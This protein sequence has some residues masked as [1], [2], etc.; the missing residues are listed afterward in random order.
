MYWDISVP[1]SYNALF[2][3]IIGNRGG[4]KTYGCKKYVISRFL[5]TG[6]QF[7]YVRRYKQELKKISTF[8]AAVSQEFPETEFNVYEGKFIINGEIAGY[9]LPL[10]TAKI[11]KS[12]EFP[13][14]TTII[15]DEFILDKGNYHYLPDEVTAFLEMYET[16]ARTRD[17]CKC[18]LL[19]NA[20]TF[21]NPYFLYFKISLP[22]NNTIAC[23]NDVLVQMVQNEEFIQ[24]KKNTRFGRL[25]SGTNYAAYA[26][27]NNFLRDSTTFVEKKTGKCGLSFNLIYNGVTYGV[28]CNMQLGKIFVSFDYNDKI[29]KT[30][31]ITKD[32]H[33]PNT[34]LLTTI[35]KQGVF[36][37]FL[38]QFEY[39][40]VY[41]ETQAIKSAMYDVIRLSNM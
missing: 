37:W 19:A 14:V 15:F 7:I 29:A 30:Y 36:K 8:F 26:I 35:R 32:D 34:L 4:G 23:K 21:A 16:V 33:T 9:Y 3:F 10:S 1:L 2:N 39:G 40:N 22:Y 20:I 12:T 6:E 17:N 11:E 38:Q 31:A 5:K 18:F 25:I 13:L 41:F 27:E 28:W 24:K